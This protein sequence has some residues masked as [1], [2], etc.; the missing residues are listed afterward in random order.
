MYQTC[1]GELKNKVFSIKKNKTSPKPEL[2][3]KIK[4]TTLVH[5]YENEKVPRFVIS[6]EGESDVC[7]AAETPD[8]VMAWVVALRSATFQNQVKLSMDSFNIIS[9]I[10]RGF[11]GKV[12]LVEMKSDG[13][14]Y[15]IKTVHKSRLI[16]SRK[17]HTILNERNILVRANNPFIV[18]LKYA[19][20]TDTKFY[21]V[22]EYV[23]GGELFRH[24]RENGKLTHQMAI[25]YIAEIALALDY[26][27]SIGVIYR[28][29]KTENI[30]LGAD[31]HIKLTDFGLSKDLS[32][33]EVTSSFCGTT[34]YIA[35]EII[36]REPY[37]YMIDW[38]ALGILTYEL[39]F[40]VTPFFNRNRSRMF[41]A[42]TNDSPPYPPDTDPKVSD[43]INKLLTKDPKK[44]SGFSQLKNHP[45][46]NGLNFDDVMAK[47]IK[48]AF[49]PDVKDKVPNNFDS[50]FTEEPAADSI[51][52][53]VEQSSSNFPGF[54]YA[55]MDIENNENNNV[56]GT[57]GDLKVEH[58]TDLKATEID[59]DITNIPTEIE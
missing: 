17:V 46:W 20:Q 24:I 8:D 53:A 27:H 3:I 9:V 22:M 55:A 7:L 12:M 40:G 57:D 32:Y 35:P 36:K 45:F 4:P 47:K 15:A 1:Y 56:N 51:A 54:S 37:S 28:D 31:G 44:R 59:P 16:S 41:Q 19:F 39:L 10:G 43:F 11:Y 2:Q 58:K 30:L 21:L 50:E 48:P 26:L 18:Q 14:L 13:N 29:L 6:N 25:L 5:V 34:E 42:I 52:S 23:P 49:I 38:W 33:L